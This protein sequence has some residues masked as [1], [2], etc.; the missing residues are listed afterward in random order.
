[1]WLFRGRAQP[2]STNV[3]YGLLRAL[4]GWRF[5]ILDN[6]PQAVA[7]AKLAKGFA[8]S[9]GERADEQIA[10]IGQLIGLDYSASPHISGIAG[11]GKQ[12]RERAFH[13]VTQYFRRLLQEGNALAVVLLDDLHC[14]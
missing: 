7:H 8:E 3:P 14:R 10:L 2:Y 11:D 12:L 5:E 4:F 1:V 6:D 13:A 9:F